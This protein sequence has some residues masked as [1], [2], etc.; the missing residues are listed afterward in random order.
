MKNKKILVDEHSDVYRFI[1]TPLLLNTYIEEK[2]DCVNLYVMSTFVAE[3]LQHYIRKIIQFYNKENINIMVDTDLQKIEEKKP[4]KKDILLHGQR[5]IAQEYVEMPF[6]VSDSNR[7]AYLAS[8]SILNNKSDG[9]I[10]LVYGGVGTGKSHLLHHVANKAFKNDKYVYINTSNGFLE[11]IKTNIEKKTVNNYINSF[12]YIDYVIID[13]FQ[14]LNNKNLAFA[15][16][17]I[18]EILNVI[19]SKK[20]NAIFSSDVS[21]YM[22]AFMHDRIRSRLISGYP[23]EIKNPDET[24]K[25]MYIDFYISKHGVPIADDIKQFIVAAARNG[26]EVGMFLNL[27]SLL[28]GGNQLNLE[29]LIRKAPHSVS[30]VKN[31]LNND[32]LHKIHTIL[33][34]FFVIDKLPHS[35]STRKAS[36]IAKIDSIAY[37]L[38]YGKMNKKDLLARLNIEAKHHTY[39]HKR[40]KSLWESLPAEISLK[41]KEIIS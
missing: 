14:V 7:I 24:I 21:P 41:I 28:H 39:Y 27:C 38:L 37:Y 6:F 4:F 40:G 29:H 2:E 15:L 17:I 31:L 26:R 8:E 12:G 3:A 22:Y 13:D 1:N 11:E 19:L 32:A 23:V 34:N 10:M 20:K 36:E 30:E 25:S 9:K 18:F 35:S 33:S 5:Y 16:D